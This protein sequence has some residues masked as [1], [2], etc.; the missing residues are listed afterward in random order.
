MSRSVNGFGLSNAEQ[1]AM[2]HPS[3]KNNPALRDYLSLANVLEFFRALLSSTSIVWISL[4]LSDPSTGAEWRELIATADDFKQVI[5]LWLDLHP[6][7][8]LNEVNASLRQLNELC[9]ST[10][11]PELGGR[12]PNEMMGLPGKKV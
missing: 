8:D 2:I 7:Q 3:F 4:S 1:M 10:P 6:A 5:Q 9:N 11:R 12:S